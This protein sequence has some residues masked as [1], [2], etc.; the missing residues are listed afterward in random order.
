LK[1]MI[2]RCAFIVPRES[3]VLEIGD[4]QHCAYFDRTS[5]SPTLFSSAG[6][7]AF[8]SNLD[9]KFQQCVSKRPIKTLITG[10][11]SKSAYIFAS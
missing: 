2:G 3:F 1:S 4:V 9:L 7:L 11:E 10:F 6:A 8:P 5:L